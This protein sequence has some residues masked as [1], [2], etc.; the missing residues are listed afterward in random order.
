[1]TISGSVRPAARGIATRLLAAVALALVVVPPLAAQVIADNSFLVEEAY[2]QETGVVQHISNWCRARDGS[3]LFTFTQEWPAPGQSDQLSYTIPVQ[4]SRGDAAALGDVAIN[5]RRQVL[6]RD[7]EPLW[8]SP[9]VSLVLPSGSTRR[10][11][12]AGGLGVQM[13][14]PVSVRLSRALVTHW[15]AGASIGRARTPA[16]TRGTIRSLSAAASAIWLAAPTF[17]LM[18]ESAWD[19]TES[20]DAAGGRGAESHFVVVP[21]ARFAINL[22]GG[23]QIVPGIGIPLGIGP[24]DG[25]RDVFLYLSVEHPFR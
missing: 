17:N 3:W 4:G 11:A 21:G 2:N 24:S 9:R 22:S 8:F 23:M 15:N 7:E 20:L 14:L 1:V 13:N 19:A 10:G 25:V 16:G 12:G 18:L 5:Y 6:G